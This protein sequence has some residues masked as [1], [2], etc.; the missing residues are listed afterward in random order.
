MITR[1]FKFFDT[2]RWNIKVVLLPLFCMTL[3][4]TLRPTY[5]SPIVGCTRCEICSCIHNEECLGSFPDRFNCSNSL[6]VNNYQRKKTDKFDGLGE[7]M[8]TVL[9]YQRYP[10]K[11][12]Q[13][14]SLKELCEAAACSKMPFLRSIRV[15]KQKHRRRL[16]IAGH[17]V[18][19]SATLLSLVFM[20][21]IFQFF[22]RRWLYMNNNGFLPIPSDVVWAWIIIL[23]WWIYGSYIW[24]HCCN[25]IVGW[26]GLAYIRSSR[27]LN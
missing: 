18:T 4:L 17:I 27:F 3:I 9:Q 24:G 25:I 10:D 13:F 5:S 6:M 14:I 1:T 26:R 7:F 2:T 20:C 19:A 21:L 23:C 22:R 16:S 15:G 12:I 11:T 8:G